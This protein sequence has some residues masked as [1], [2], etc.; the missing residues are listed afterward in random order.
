[1]KSGIY[2]IGHPTEVE[3]MAQ[4]E[5]D[6]GRIFLTAA[7]FQLFRCGKNNNFKILSMY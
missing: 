3:A 4:R 5:E 6:S 7:E 1:M 2:R